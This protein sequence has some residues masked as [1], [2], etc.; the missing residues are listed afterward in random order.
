[1]SVPL[2]TEQQLLADQILEQ[3]R[4]EFAESNAALVFE[5]NKEKEKVQALMEFK[6]T[7]ELETDS[8]G[9]VVKK[10]MK[11]PKIGN[12]PRFSGERSK[13]RSFINQFELI[14]KL[15]KS[16]FLN[17]AAVIDYLGTLL[18]GDAM[19]WYNRFLEHPESYLDVLVSWKTFKEIFFNSFGDTNR[20][21]TS[22]NAIQ[23]LKQGT[24]TTSQYA[25][26]FN[27][28]A[29]DLDWD[30]PALMHNF[31]RGLPLRIRESLAIM[32]KDPE[33]LEE[34]MQICIK[35]DNNL[36]DL[37]RSRPLP[38]K[39]AAPVG[40]QH[41]R[42]GNDYWTR[43]NYGNDYRRADQF[44]PRADFAAPV[45]AAGATPTVT[46]NSAPSHGDNGNSTAADSP[47]DAMDLDVVRL[48]PQDRQA[49][50]NEGRC[51]ECGGVG[52][53]QNSCPSGRRGG[54]RNYR[55]R[56]VSSS[57]GGGNG[58][59]G[60]GIRFGNFNRSEGFQNGQ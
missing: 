53:V 21:I 36:S 49:Y 20:K 23:E 58:G 27:S 3:A 51:F 57:R 13:F 39:P 32:I 56:N 35:V 14:V 1:M 44:V 54:S 16:R 59:R 31:K 33:S 52:H 42:V 5:L 45:E 4:K 28:L 19:S 11:E 30:Q 26:E 24:R 40:R 60:R 29:S 48:S 2:S 18:D 12:P 8:N 10:E 34:L 47:S 55:G 37:A 46:L 15:Q 41:S 9:K 25:A 50:V 38:Y 22:A 6:L 43:N 17:D 7:T